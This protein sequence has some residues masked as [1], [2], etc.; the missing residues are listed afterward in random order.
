MVV[1][2]HAQPLGV[3]DHSAIILAHSNE[4]HCQEVPLRTIYYVQSVKL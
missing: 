2:G 1:T 3:S 4:S